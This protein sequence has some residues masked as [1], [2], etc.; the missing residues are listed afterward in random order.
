MIMFPRVIFITFKISG[1]NYEY[2]NK[3]YKTTNERITPNSS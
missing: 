2:R 3:A 1:E